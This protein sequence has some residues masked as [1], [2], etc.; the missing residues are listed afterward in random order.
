[1]AFLYCGGKERLGGLV[2]YRYLMGHGREGLVVL[3]Y[4]ILLPRGLCYNLYFFPPPLLLLCGLLFGGNVGRLITL[5]SFRLYLY[6]LVG[7]RFLPLKTHWWGWSL[8][9]RLLRL[10]LNS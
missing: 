9:T 3:D 2:V 6:G 8:G 1:M 4:G 5:Y 7:S 10:G